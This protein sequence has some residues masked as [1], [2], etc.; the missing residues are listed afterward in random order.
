VTPRPASDARRGP[1]SVP[2]MGKAGRSRLLR[3]PNDGWRLATP[4]ALGHGAQRTLHAVILAMC[5]P[6]PAPRTE[7]LIRRVELGSMT[8]LRYMHPAVA[9]ALVLGLR[10]LDFLPLVT[11]S[12]RHRFHRLESGQASELLARWSRSRMRALRLLV[13]G[14]RGLVL[15]VYFDQTEVHAALGYEP[16]GFMRDR[17]K[18][19]ERLEAGLDPTSSRRLVPLGTSRTTSERP[20]AAPPS[21]R[22]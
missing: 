22:G 4:Y 17:I 1:S 16:V 14:A 13:Q 3:H 7:E 10:V 21:S 8:L 9:F 15:S 18:R 12:S 6:S 2:A 20:E 11:F 19:R 5:P